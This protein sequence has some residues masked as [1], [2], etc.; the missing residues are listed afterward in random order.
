[1][2]IIGFVFIAG[3]VLSI[4]LKN[5]Q[6][7]QWPLIKSASNEKIKTIFFDDK[8]IVNPSI[9]NYTFRYNQVSRITDAKLCLYIM[10]DEA[11][12]VMIKKDAFTKG[13]YDSLVSFLRERLI[14]NPKILKSLTRK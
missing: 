14:D 1:M 12:V 4:R 7:K 8:L 9:E 3:I 10:F 13:D 11:V 6:I 5:Q 2:L